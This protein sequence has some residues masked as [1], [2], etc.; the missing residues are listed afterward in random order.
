[1]QVM[2][3]YASYANYAKPKCAQYR[4]RMQKSPGQR[5]PPERMERGSGDEAT[6]TFSMTKGL[7]WPTGCEVE[8]FLPGIP[9]PIP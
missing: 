5:L 1:M 7:I 4:Q 9:R 6:K 8:P 2:Q 3:I